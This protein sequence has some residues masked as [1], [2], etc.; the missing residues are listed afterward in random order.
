MWPLH[1]RPKDEYVRLI[2]DFLD[3]R[4]LPALNETLNQAFEDYHSEED[5]TA[6][7]TSVAY[8]SELPS[9][10]TLLA[11]FIETFPLSLHP[12]QVDWA[13]YL[14]WQGQIDEGSNEARAYL[15]RVYSAGLENYFEQYDLLRDGCSRAFLILT[16]VYTEAGARSYS[17]RIIQN[18]MLLDLE[19]FWQQRFQGEIHRL[20]KER[21]AGTNAKLDE[22]WERFFRR[23]EGAPKLLEVCAQCRLPVLGRRVETL[24]GM[25]EEDSDYRPGDEEIIQVLYRTEQGA[26][27]LV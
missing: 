10:E 4:D 6:W 7:C 13:D 27:V 22:M 11:R 19:P 16:A 8:G 23:G 20:D 3:E 9:A 2:Q 12:V 26:F 5:F 17:S 24:A 21:S 1:V 15:N 25:M 18:A 14:I